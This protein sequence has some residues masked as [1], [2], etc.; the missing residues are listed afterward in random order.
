MGCHITLSGNITVGG[1][2][3]GRDIATDGTKLD[4]VEANA[5]ADQTKADIDA[6]NI[7]ADTLDGQHG[8]YTQ[9]MPTQRYLTLWTAHLRHLLYAKRTG[10]GSW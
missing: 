1:T 5:T 10:S 4:G 6:L 8:S 3:D 2:V 7:D 9:R